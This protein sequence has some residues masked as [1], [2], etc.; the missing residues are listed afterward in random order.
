[1]KTHPEVTAILAAGCIGI[2][3]IMPASARGHNGEHHEERPAAGESA[4]QS[5]GEKF[6]A[7]IKRFQFCP[8]RIEVKSGEETFL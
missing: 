6:D 4:A 7:A 8:R 3:P 5:P 1:V 2:L